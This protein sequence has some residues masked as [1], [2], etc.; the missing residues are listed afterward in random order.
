MYIYDLRYDHD[1]SL[2]GNSPDLANTLKPVLYVPRCDLV[3]SYHI[4]FAVQ[5]HDWPYSMKFA[6]YAHHDII[7]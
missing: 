4:V 3:L 5:G 7:F 6:E 1:F 2:I